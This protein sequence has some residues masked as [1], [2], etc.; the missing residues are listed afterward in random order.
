MDRKKAIEVL[1]ALSDCNYIG[2]LSGEDIEAFTMAIRCLK[3]DEMYGLEYE[4]PEWADKLLKENERLKK[5]IEMLK[6]DRECEKPS[7]KWIPVSERL[8]EPYMFVNA[9]CRSLVDDREDW[10]IETIY[11]PIPKEANKK[12][13]SDWGNIPMLNCREA[14]VVAW[15]ERVIPEPYKVEGQGENT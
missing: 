5:E 8:P 12:G 11:L 15:M 3:V 7:G 4:D 2:S 6:L 9:T 1:E 14:E 13:Y 10:V